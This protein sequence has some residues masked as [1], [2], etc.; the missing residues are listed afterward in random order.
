M[1]GIGVV[2]AF[3]EGDE[4]GEHEFE[5]DFPAKCIGTLCEKANAM[6]KIA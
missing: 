3:H 6:P 5:I 2:E 1:H 4:G